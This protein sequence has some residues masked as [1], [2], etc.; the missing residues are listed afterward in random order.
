MKLFMHTQLRAD[1]QAECLAREISL[2]SIDPWKKAECWRIGA[3]KLW[4][5]MKFL[6]VPWTARRSNL[7]ILKGINPEYSLEGLML[8]LKVLYLELDVKSQLIG[9]HP[10]AGKN[11]KQKEEEVVEDEMVRLHHWFNGHEFEQTPGGNEGYWSLACYSPWGCK[12]LDM[13]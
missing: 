11:W 7:S 9:K 3:F 12:G 8:E 6:T 2:Y 4:C 13:T 1:F 10:D 5:W